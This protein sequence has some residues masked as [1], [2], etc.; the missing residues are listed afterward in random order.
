M[1]CNFPINL[2]SCP[3]KKTGRL[4]LTFLQ[5]PIQTPWSLVLMKKILC[6]KYVDVLVVVVVI[7]LRT[8][9][10]LLVPSCVLVLSC[11]LS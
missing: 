10:L 7:V 4:F 8:T 9:S 6:R 2:T 1:H 11:L 5:I 3:L